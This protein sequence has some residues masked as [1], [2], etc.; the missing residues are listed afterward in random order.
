MAAGTDGDDDRAPDS[1]EFVV[2]RI[3]GRRYA[4]ELGRVGQVVRRPNVT[5][6]PRTPPLLL[7][8]TDVGGDVTAVVDGHRLLGGGRDRDGVPALVLFERERTGQ[9]AGVYVDHVEGIQAVDVDEIHPVDAVTGPGSDDEPGSPASR[10]PDAEPGTA[11]AETGDPPPEWE[12]ADPSLFR[13]VLVD[14]CAVGVLDP[15]RVAEAAATR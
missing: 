12:P 7:G 9:S 11:D 2:F 15:E 3:G 8:V 5:R 6:V 4:V 14:D 13:A 10:D 1:V